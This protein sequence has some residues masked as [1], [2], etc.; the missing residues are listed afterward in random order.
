M[1]YAGLTFSINVKI[2]AT[3]AVSSIVL[4]TSSLIIYEL[5]VKSGIQNAKEQ[6]EYTNLLSTYETKAKGLNSEVMQEFIEAEKKRRFDVEEKKITT[7]IER[8]DKIQEHIK[9]SKSIIDKYRFK[10]NKLKLLKLYKAKDNIV[11]D[12]PYKYSEQF[13]QLRYSAGDSE[14]KEFKPHDALIYFRK[15][16]ISKYTMLLTT[17]LVGINSI[18]LT[19][20]GQN[21]IIA[22]FMTAISAVTLIASLVSGFTSGYN[23]IAISSTG[24]Y[25]TAISFIEKAEVYCNK[26][27]KKLRDTDIV[28]TDEIP[29]EYKTSN[30][31]NSE[32]TKIEDGQVSINIFDKLLK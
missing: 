3:I 15:K 24:V 25:K 6:T 17:T 22:L 10:W 30:T 19:V 23:S 2:V 31:E 21:W 18:S 1:C 26:Y 32:E 5:W 8:L 12:M 9:D 20:G 16:R 7:E 28:I 11:I 14:Y 27:N 13:D 4:A 29:K